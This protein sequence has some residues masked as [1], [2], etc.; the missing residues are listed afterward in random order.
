[1]L[2]KLLSCMRS[3]IIG[4]GG[5]IMGAFLR[6]LGQN[7]TV[8][9]TNL[10]VLR[11]QQ[12]GALVDCLDSSSHPAFVSDFMDFFKDLPQR[13]AEGVELGVL[14]K[15]ERGYAFAEDGLSKVP[16]FV[17]LVFRDDGM[18]AS[19]QVT[20]I[21]SW[22]LY[23]NFPE[24]SVVLDGEK[25][26]VMD[27]GFAA[28]GVGRQRQGGEQRDSSS[29]VADNAVAVFTAM[30]VAKAQGADVFAS[31]S[32]PMSN[33][34][35][36][37][38][39]LAS[40][41]AKLE[42]WGT[43]LPVGPAELDRDRASVAITKAVKS[44][45]GVGPDITVKLGTVLEDGSV[46]PGVAVLGRHDDTM[47]IARDKLRVKV[48]ASEWQPVSKLIPEGDYAYGPERMAD[49]IR[50]FLSPDAGEIDG[51]SAKVDGAVKE[52]K[53][54]NRVPFKFGPGPGDVV[55]FS[56]NKLEARLNSE[57]ATWMDI[58]L[59]T[60]QGGKIDIATNGRSNMDMAAGMIAMTEQAFTS[61]EWSPVSLSLPTHA[62]GKS[63]TAIQLVRARRNAETGKPEYETC[64]VD[65]A[66]DT[67]ERMG[68][69]TVLREALF[70]A[71]Y[72]AKLEADFNDSKMLEYLNR[73][74]ETWD[75][76]TFYSMPERAS[77]LL[78]EL[79]GN[80][81]AKVAVDQAM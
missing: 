79:I 48:G 54:R 47:V 38:N 45:L 76:L 2:F 10:V 59:A 52:D 30:I 3:F 74:K 41:I 28:E 65:L 13:L 40:Q 26:P 46:F 12:L 71:S 24:G 78:G 72:Q 37:L 75:G 31:P 9:D 17:G 34:G 14:V 68:E 18:E 77:S 5:L 51:D 57:E 50:T 19:D 32:N 80:Y 62:E 7:A 42:G 49:H 29:M 20:K 63:A 70:G 11:D 43:I 39:E 33:L 35:F 69:A 1:M 21:C 22:P 73:I 67:G 55:S 16:G 44:K 61:P 64:D 60:S 23:G 6:G 36:G 56:R 58:M 53:K 4:T 8:Y 25:L 66:V 27:G 81:Q 15:K